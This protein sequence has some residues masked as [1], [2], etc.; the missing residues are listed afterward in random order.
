MF[1][2]SECLRIS[3]PASAQVNRTGEG[4]CLDSERRSCSGSRSAT[5]CLPWPA[6]GAAGNQFRRDY[7]AEPQLCRAQPRQSRFDPQRRSSFKPASRCTPGSRQD[8]RQSRARPRPG[9]VR[10]ASAPEPRLARR[11]RHDFRASRAGHRRQRHVGLGHV[12]SQR[13]DG[14]A[15]PGHLRRPLP[16]DRRQPQDH[17]ASQPRMAGDAGAAAHRVRGQEYFVVHDPV[18]PAFG[19]EGAANHM[20]LA[21]SY[22]EPGVELFVYGVS[23]APFRRGSI[24][25][26]RRR[27]RGSTG[28]T[29][30]APCSSSNRRR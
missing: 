25:R 4:L 28:S 19:D 29:P 11:T 27:S 1:S 6:D 10:P 3:S 9:P 16:P 12:G 26:H 22:G 7:R 13:G 15:R 24:S 8:A 5:A 23:A 14:V 17:A 30:T 21:P 2:P 18:P 20:R